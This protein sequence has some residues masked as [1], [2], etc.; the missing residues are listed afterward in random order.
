MAA[1]RR[2]SGLSDF[3]DGRFREGLGVLVDAF[4]ARDDVHA[5]G[6]LF[7]REYCTTCWSTA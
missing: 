3:G 7:F 5:F 2:R 1:A 6:R 4:N